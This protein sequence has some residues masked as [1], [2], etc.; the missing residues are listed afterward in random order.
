LVSAESAL[1]FDSA[2]GVQKVIFLEEFD[3]FWA[4]MY[5]LVR[6]HF[7]VFLPLLGV[8]GD[9]VILGIITHE[10]FFIKSKNEIIAEL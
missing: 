6:R 4:G 8:F 10:T 2:L 1:F 5:I 9:D 3:G 7:G